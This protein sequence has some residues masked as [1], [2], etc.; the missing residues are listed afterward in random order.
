VG[1]EILRD[2]SLD[3][4]ENDT[5]WLADQEILDELEG[6]DFEIEY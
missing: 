5:Q 2:G 1:V 6:L 4:M 3:A